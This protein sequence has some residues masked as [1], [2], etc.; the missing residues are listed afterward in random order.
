[1][2]TFSSPLAPDAPLSQ[3]FAPRLI[4]NN[5]GEGYAETAPDGPN[6][7]PAQLTLRWSLL[8]LV[9]KQALDSFFKAHIGAAFFFTVP[10]ETVAR[11]WICN[12]F[13]PTQDATWWSYDATFNERFNLT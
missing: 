9:Q 3:Q 1:M 4:Q 6:A 13:K 5:F 10:D 11:K 12:N 2:D 8:T 7:S